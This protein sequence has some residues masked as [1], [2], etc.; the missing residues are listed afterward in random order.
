MGNPLRHEPLVTG[1][2]DD[3]LEKIDQDSL[4]RA[5]FAEH[6]TSLIARNHR[7][8]SSVVYGLEGAWGSGK[9]SVINFIRQ[10]LTKDSGWRIAEYT[11]WATSGTDS[12]FAEFFASIT[13]V[14]PELTVADESRKRL[15]QYANLA[16]PIAGTVPYI[17]NML[18]GAAEWAEDALSKPWK[19]SFTEVSDE[20]QKLGTPILI[21]VDDIDRLQPPELL[22]LLKV[23]RLLGRFPGIDFLLA[24]DEETVIDTLSAG[25]WGGIG[26]ERARAFMEK[27][28]QYPLSIPPLLRTQTARMLETGISEIVTPIHMETT[29][30]KDRIFSVL[31]RS[32]PAELKTPRSVRRFLA[33]VE[34]QFQVHEI[35]ETDDVDL[36]LATFLR[37]Q[38]PE[39]FTELQNWKS[40]LTEQAR[41]IMSVSSTQEKTDWLPLLHLVN[42]KRRETAKEALEA[43]FPAMKD[44]RLGRYDIGRFA[45]PDYFDRYLSQTIPDGDIRDAE[46][47]YALAR[48]SEEDTSALRALVIT[49][50]S[51][52]AQLALSK[53]LDR[54]PDV[55]YYANAYRE[56]GGPYS[57]TLLASGMALIAELPD[58]TKSWTNELA[59]C[60]H[61]LATLVRIL[62]TE[63]SSQD[64]TSALDQCQDVERRAHVLSTATASID[65][66]HEQAQVAI[67]KILH[68]E[69]FKILPTLIADLREKNNADGTWAYPFLFGLVAEYGDLSKLQGT[70]QEGILSNEFTIED[71]AARFVSFSY[72]LGGSRAKPWAAS[73]SANLFSTVAGVGAQASELSEKGDW[74]DTS[75][76]RRK[77]FA[78]KH[79]RDEMSKDK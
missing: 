14:A 30:E 43:I 66:L 72:L 46:I 57:P 38:F 39:I 54:Y 58:R 27:I 21:V 51:D 59:Q 17:G 36:I 26:A 49:D 74:E 19:V 23:V 8:D 12:L 67:N 45:H 9:S 40:R 78:A 64:L 41:P 68:R 52:S 7:P 48:A 79:L 62:L 50:D 60:T 56:S 29:L 75:W 28:V 33:Q 55:A 10:G 34:Q 35:D 71:V 22:D 11:P 63:D 20:I 70:V 3:P 2:N 13:E 6:V 76:S 77:T 31:T 42:E 4:R 44:M 5:P 24:Y 37:V 61:W 65:S 73:F 16:R 69:T 25:H 15:L 47:T 18:T 1:F 32:M 53:I